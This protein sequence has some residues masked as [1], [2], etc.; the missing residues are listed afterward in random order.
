MS[1][2]GS[3]AQERV[4]TAEEKE[5]VPLNINKYRCQTY[6]NRIL[7]VID[8]FNPTMMCSLVTNREHDNTDK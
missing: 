2:V 5:T 4:I 6:H 1:L 3:F 8:A 7:N